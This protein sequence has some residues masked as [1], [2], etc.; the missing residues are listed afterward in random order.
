M[1]AFRSCLP[2]RLIE[3]S[4]P[5]WPQSPEPKIEIARLLEE[6]G[7]V[8]QAK[9]QLVDALTVDPH[10]ARALTALG[11]LRD[12]T[13]NY[14][15][16]LSDYRTAFSEFA[17]KVQLARALMAEPQILLLD[18]PSM[19]LSPMM[20]DQVFQT[21]CDINARGVA[22]L[23]VS[24]DLSVVKHIVDAHHAA[25]LPAQHRG[26]SP[27]SRRGGQRDPRVARTRQPGDHESIRGNHGAHERGRDE[28]V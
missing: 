7:Q 15:Q 1:P 19:G 23:L 18:E 20:V 8:E 14:A 22:I 27:R 4:Y 9:S 17:R 26:A 28:V 16:A 10:N 24:H 25:C 2:R 6:S 21:I 5:S 13:G 3:A 11:R 12:Q